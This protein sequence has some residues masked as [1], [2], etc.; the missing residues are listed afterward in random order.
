MTRQPAREGYFLLDAPSRK[1]VE[2]AIRLLTHWEWLTSPVTF[3]LE[4][5]PEQGPCVLVT[6]HRN[7][8]KGVGIDRVKILLGNGIMVSEGALWQRQRRMMQPFFHRRHMA[9]FFTNIERGNRELLDR[10]QAAAERG[11]SVNLTED[12]SRMTLDIV[13]RALFSE[14]LEV[15][16]DKVGGNPFAVVADE[17][18][19]DLRF[20]ARFRALA[21][22]IGELIDRR[23]AHAA[24]RRDL[25]AMLM[26]ARDKS[27]GEPMPDKSLIDEVIFGCTGFSSS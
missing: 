23:R 18:A 27:S 13:L 4:N 10:W 21:R 5:I 15:L 6:N 1:A 22:P 12:V 17:S 19:R 9:D 26:Q 8:T 25:L 20:A 24:P 3:G 11:E 2:L 7:Y 14:D 16:A